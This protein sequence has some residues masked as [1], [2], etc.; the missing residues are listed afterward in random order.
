[1]KRSERDGKDDIDANDARVRDAQANLGRE[2]RKM[3]EMKN[4]R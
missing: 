1:M 2:M 3:R 4:M